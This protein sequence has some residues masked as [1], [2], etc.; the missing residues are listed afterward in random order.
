[1]N[2]NIFQLK[3]DFLIKN[4]YFNLS[5]KISIFNSL[6]SIKMTWQVEDHKN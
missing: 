5:F 3:I 4:I 1:M 6:S 2:L